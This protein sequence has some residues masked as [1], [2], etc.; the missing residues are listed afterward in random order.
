MKLEPSAILFDLDGVL[1][2]SFDAWLAALND[3]L[4]YFNYKELTKDEFI[5]RYWGHDLFDNIEKMNLTYEV[6]EAC[7]KSYKNHIDKIKI[8]PDTIDILT[9]FDKYRK[10]VITNTPKDSA[11]LVL[12][13]FN[14]YRYFEFVLTSNDVKKS[15][16]DPEI[17]IKSCTLLNLDPSEVILIGDTKS[18]VEAGRAA[19]CKVI[20]INVEADYKIKKLS[21]L[22]ELF[23]L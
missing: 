5:D 13:Q 8:Y 10:G 21:E 17:V 19:G 15:K 7:N 14:I 18:D 2:D 11:T 16:P 4:K 20:G 3:A 23:L 22:T 12:K 6:G 1:V 9:K